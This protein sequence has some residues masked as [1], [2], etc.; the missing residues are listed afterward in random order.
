MRTWMILVHTFRVPY[1]ISVG[2]LRY[3]GMI[4]SQ[5]WKSVEISIDHLM[6]YQQLSFTAQI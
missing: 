2:M 6:P 1:Y 3:L 4:V 5:A